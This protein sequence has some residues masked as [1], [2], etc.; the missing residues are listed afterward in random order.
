MENEQFILQLQK[1][2]DK[3][4]RNEERIIKLEKESGELHELVTSVAVIADQLKTMNGKFDR[5]E[6]K[7]DTMERKPAKWLDWL[8]KLVF[9]AIIGAVI[10]LALSQIGL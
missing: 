9:G 8:E 4:D 5:L 7:V 3:A 2:T 1:T 6:G 10:A